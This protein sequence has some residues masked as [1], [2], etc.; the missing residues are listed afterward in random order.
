MALKPTIYKLQLDVADSDRHHYQ[1]YN[2]TLAQHPSETL[3]RMA[4]RALAFALNAHEDLVFTKGL[5]TDD[6]PDL[7]QQ[8]LDGQIA[9]WIEVGQPKPERL[10][11]AQGRAAKVLLYPFG[12]TADTWWSLEQKHIVRSDKLQIAQFDWVQV[13]A[14]AGAVERT[15]HWSVSVAGGELFVD[16]GSG[17]YQLQLK[18]L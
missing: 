13:S 14:L 9:V 17:Q 15:M 11:K 12:K 4:V 10:K 1:S 8:T 18:P 16:T 3:E 5:S 2:L 6:E 7:W